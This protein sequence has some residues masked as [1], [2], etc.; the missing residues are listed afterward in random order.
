LLRKEL[1]LN[2]SFDVLIGSESQKQIWRALC[3]PYADKKDICVD[4]EAKGRFIDTVDLGDCL[5]VRSYILSS[6]IKELDKL[7][8]ELVNNNS[9]QIYFDISHVLYV[10]PDPYHAELAY[11]NAQSSD[12]GE[13]EISMLISWVIC[14][15]L[16]QKRLDIYLNVG[17]NVDQAIKFIEL[18]HS[19]AFSASICAVTSISEPA[20]I[21]Q[22]A[23]GFFAVADRNFC[24]GI[25]HDNENA[26]IA[27]SFYFPL[28]QIKK[29][30]I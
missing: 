4:V 24:F 17:D 29:V 15:A 27:A 8:A 26:L 1:D 22:I 25:S 19:R 13:D 6:D 2:L 5:D 30:I 28:N 9:D 3:V 23:C 7:I 20:I 21:E 10:R 18:L 14:R 12:I 11:K 16:M